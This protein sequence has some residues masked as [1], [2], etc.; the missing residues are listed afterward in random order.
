M[1]L[2]D[3]LVSQNRFDW[4][5]WMGDEVVASV[6]GGGQSFSESLGL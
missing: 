5:T 2:P 4:L 3:R 1:L 6:P